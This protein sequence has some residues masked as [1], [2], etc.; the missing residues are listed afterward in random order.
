MPAGR[1]PAG[2]RP[3]ADLLSFVWQQIKVGKAKCLNASD[4]TELHG[5]KENA[6]DGKYLRLQHRVGYRRTLAEKGVSVR[7]PTIGA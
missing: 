3:A 6:V 1:E 2:F 4:T 7:F 5:W